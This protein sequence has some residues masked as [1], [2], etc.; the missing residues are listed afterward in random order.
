MSFSKLD[1]MFEFC[2]SSA[3]LFVKIFVERYYNWLFMPFNALAIKAALLGTRT[4]C[5]IYI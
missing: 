1:K 2:V 4:I 5:L 3:F